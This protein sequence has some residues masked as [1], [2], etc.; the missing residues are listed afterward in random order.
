MCRMFVGI[1]VCMYVCVYI[2]VC[3]CEYVGVCMY[4]YVYMYIYL[5]K[6]KKKKPVCK[7][8]DYIAV[9]SCACVRACVC[10]LCFNTTKIETGVQGQ[11]AKGIL[12]M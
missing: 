12:C 5:C 6:A 10:K 7:Y 1:Y 9:H 3:M 4:V 11:G 8:V 2:Y